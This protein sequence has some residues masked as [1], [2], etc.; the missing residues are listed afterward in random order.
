MKWMAI[1]LGLLLLTACAGQNHSPSRA[2]TPGW[3][4]RVW[5][6]QAACRKPHWR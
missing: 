4:W 5:R 2:A 3:T 1:L 6:W